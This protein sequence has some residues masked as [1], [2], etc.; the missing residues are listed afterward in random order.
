MGEGWTS[1]WFNAGVCFRP[2]EKKKI[3]FYFLCR[4][5]CRW[6]EQHLSQDHFQPQVPLFLSQTETCV[7]CQSKRWQTLKSSL[8]HQNIHT[9]TRDLGLRNIG[10]QA[11]FESTVTKKGSN[12]SYNVSTTLTSLFLMVQG[13]SKPN[14]KRKENE[15][16]PHFLL[17][18]YKSAAGSL[19]CRL[20]MVSAPAWKS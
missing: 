3:H 10:T 19:K 20:Y 14:R 12:Y 15:N 1:N 7:N 17:V 8:K 13:N 6:T 11:T 2:K 4:R 9:L 5:C 16:S 18:K